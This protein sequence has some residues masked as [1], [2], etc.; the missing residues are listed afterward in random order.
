[1]YFHFFIQC[2]FILTGVITL[3]AALCD[4]DWFFKS[5]HTQI[6]VVKLGRNWARL[7]YGSLSVILIL[8]A[9]YFFLATCEAFGLAI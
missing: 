7:L 3:L 5:H 2:I 9:I 6:V 4:S 8:L 1:M